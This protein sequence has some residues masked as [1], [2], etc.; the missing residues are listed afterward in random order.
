MKTDEIRKSDATMVGNFFDSV[1]DKLI[2][3]EQKDLLF[4]DENKVQI[5]PKKMQEKV[6]F[7]TLRNGILFLK[8]K[9]SVWRAELAAIKPTVLAKCNLLLGRES[10]KEVRII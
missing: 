3:G 6:T 7:D 9:S 2:S 8:S 1:L 10:V 5:L 4:L